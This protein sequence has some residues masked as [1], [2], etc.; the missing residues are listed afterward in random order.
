MSTRAYLRKDPATWRRKVVEQG[1]PAAQYAAFEAVLCL[2]EEQPERGRF[3]SERL[4]RLLLDEPRDGVRIGWGRHIPFLIE[5]GDLIRQ[6]DGSLYIDGW[7]EWQEGDWKVAERVA[8][9]RHRK[10]VHQSNGVTPYVTVPVTPG[11]TV[12]VT[13]PV[14]VGTVLARAAAA[15][16]AAVSIS[17]G[18]GGRPLPR[19]PQTTRSRSGGNDGER[20]DEAIARARA[21]LEDP[22][23]SEGVKEAAR[24]ALGQLGVQADDPQ[25][26]ATTADTSATQ[27]SVA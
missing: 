19:S 16:A 5:H 25:P 26:P 10:D 12:G 7:D 13:G 3:R 15:E 27:G 1:Y 22:D 11:V 6:T 8:R 18:G 24:F 20:R 23:A 2:G 17:G 21:R 14:T 9:I 4:L